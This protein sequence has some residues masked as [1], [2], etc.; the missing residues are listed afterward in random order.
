[1]SLTRPDTSNPTVP[2]EK[3]NKKRGTSKAAYSEFNEQQLI[4]LRLT[5]TTALRYAGHDGVRAAGLN[6]VEFIDLFTQLI[7]KESNFKPDA[8]SL[9]GAQGLGQ[10]MPATSTELGVSNP[11]DP[12]Q[13]LDAS[14]RYLTSQMQRFKSAKLALAAYN[15]GPTRVKRFGG[16]P[17]FEETTNYVRNILSETGLLRTRRENKPLIPTKRFHLPSRVDFRLKGRQSVWEF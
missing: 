15:A 17:P 9:A 6:T 11:F 1:M 5:E 16:V 4:Y 10:L 2:E 3:F 8:I 12:E 13:N 7:Q 14:A